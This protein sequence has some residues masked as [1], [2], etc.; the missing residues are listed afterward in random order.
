M[1][2][3]FKLLRR[4]FSWVLECAERIIYKDDNFN[5]Y[6]PVSDLEVKEAVFQLGGMK[7]PDPDGFTGL[8]YQ[9]S[10]EVVADQ[11]YGFVKDFFANGGSL[12][13]LNKTNIVL[14]P[15]SDNADVV[16]QFRPISLCD[17][18]YKVISKVISNRLRGIMPKIVSEYQ[19]AFVLEG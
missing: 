19:R 1:L 4:D 14:I 16:G 6:C 12:E 8:F 7:A 18:S 15:K 13:A 9:H 11:V 17:F 10:W 2:I 5:L 3:C